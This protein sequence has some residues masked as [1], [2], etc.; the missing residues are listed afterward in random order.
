MDIIHT[1]WQKQQSRIEDGI[2]FGTDDYIPLEGGPDTG[3]AI[4]VRRLIA[5]IVASSPDHWCELGEKVV[6]RHDQRDMTIHAGATSWEGEGFLAV[7]SASTR[8]L[9]WLLHLSTSEEFIEA[10]AED[11]VIRAV[12]G[13]YPMRYEWSIPIYS[14]ER[15]TVEGHRAA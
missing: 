2:F 7:V 9:L 12:S 6:S 15:F 11:D 14:P 10:K 1:R 13:G 4:G 3:Y 5:D 8:Q